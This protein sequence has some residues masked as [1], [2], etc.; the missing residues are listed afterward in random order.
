GASPGSA[1]KNN[2]AKPQWRA[3]PCGDR[4]L[5]IDLEQPDVIQ[6]NK[7]AWEIADRLTQAMLRG[8]T[9]VVPSMAAVVVHYDPVIVAA[10][11]GSSTPWQTLVNLIEQLMVD[12]TSQ[13]T[14]SSR[15]IILPVCYGGEYGIDLEEVART[16]GLTTD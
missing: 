5:V 2:T 7:Q 8:V 15:E 3:V 4:C 6:S 14:S 12:S 13:E 10:L 16:C 9:D 11:D 1:I